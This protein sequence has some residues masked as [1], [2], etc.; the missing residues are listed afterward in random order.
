MERPPRN[1][2]RLRHARAENST[3]WA[4][5]RAAAPSRKHASRSRVFIN[6]GTNREGKRSGANSSLRTGTAGGNL[7]PMVKK[8]LHTRMRVN[9]LERTVKFYE[10]ALE[11][12]VARRNVS[13]RG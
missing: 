10:Q 5:S 1:G 4:A 13:P 8:L 11:L 12:K 9:D 2:P 3:D 6:E 7:A